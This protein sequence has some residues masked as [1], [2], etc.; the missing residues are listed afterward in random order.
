MQNGLAVGMGRH[1]GGSS[2]LK[3]I[4]KV[5]VGFVLIGM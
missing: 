4:L 3:R 1:Q 5:E 2:G